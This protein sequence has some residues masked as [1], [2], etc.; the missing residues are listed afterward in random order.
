MEV[1]L[2]DAELDDLVEAAA[3][4]E[5]ITA[6]EAKQI[7]YLDQELYQPY[8]RPRDQRTSIVQD[9]KVKLADPKAN[10][11]LIRNNAEGEAREAIQILTDILPDI[12]S[13]NMGL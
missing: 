13:R 7:R 10:A 12:C 2:A 3:F 4:D 8:F 1:K 6:E 11:D 9:M 5:Y